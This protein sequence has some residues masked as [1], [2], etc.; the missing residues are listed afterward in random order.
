MSNT[1]L[2]VFDRTVQKTN[3]WLKNLMDELDWQDSQE[4]YAALRVTLQA[5]RDRLTVEEVAQLGAQLPMLI[6]GFYYAG[7]DPT[8]K[9]LKVRAARGVPGAN[10]RTFCY[11]GRPR[12]ILSRSRAQCSA[13]SLNGSPTEK[14]KTSS[15]FCPKSCGVSGRRAVPIGSC[16]HGAATDDKANEHGLTTTLMDGG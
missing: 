10:R 2:D 15:M 5:L 13:C 7:W 3:S 8:G 11:G 16:G 1:G 4:A 9:P 14:S 12:S 6:R